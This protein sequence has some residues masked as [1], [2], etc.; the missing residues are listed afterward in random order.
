VYI[1]SCNTLVIQLT[2]PKEWI[3]LVRIR[4]GG[5]QLRMRFHKM[6]GIS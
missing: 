3:D 2:I 6:L 5:G 1:G 4:T